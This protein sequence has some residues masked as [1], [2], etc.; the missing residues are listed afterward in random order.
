MQ[1]YFVVILTFTLLVGCSGGLT[2]V[3]IEATAKAN[4]I[5]T[6][7]APPL[8]TPTDELEGKLKPWHGWDKITTF[9][10]SGMD[11]YCPK[12]NITRPWRL[13]WFVGMPSN[14]HGNGSITIEVWDDNIPSKW[15][16]DVLKSNHSWNEYYSPVYTNEV[17]SLCIHAESRYTQYVILLEQKAK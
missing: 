2:Q 17:K 16:N 14:T 8:P 4:A 7:V 6:D 10:S 9:Y 13:R 15:K 3:S 1:C 12:V 5:A 11:S